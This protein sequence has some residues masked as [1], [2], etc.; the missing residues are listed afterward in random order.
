MKF[1]RSSRFQCKRPSGPVPVGI[2]GGLIFWVAFAA[3]RLP[4]FRRGQELSRLCGSLPICVNLRGE[5]KC[6]QGVGGLG[7]RPF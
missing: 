5:S 1:S 7:A 6:L 3:M 4:E 2:L